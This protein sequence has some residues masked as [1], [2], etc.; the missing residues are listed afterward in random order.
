[1]APSAKRTGRQSRGFV[2]VG[3]QRWLIAADS[4]RKTCRSARGSIRGASC[5]PPCLLRA[6]SAGHAYR[7]AVESVF[8]Q[9]GIEKVAPSFNWRYVRLA[10]KCISILQCQVLDVLN[11]R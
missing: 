4:E 10:S 7:I 3:P 11:R 1:M 2:L 6:T 9:L 8:R 5:T